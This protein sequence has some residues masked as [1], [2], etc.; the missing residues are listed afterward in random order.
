MGA[1]R[2]QT[3]VAMPLTARLM[4]GSDGQQSRIF[5]LR[6]GVRLHGDRIIAGDIAELRGQIGDQF[7]IAFLLIRRC[8]G[9]DGR[10][11]RPAQRHHFRRRVQ[12]HGAGAKRDHRPV[13]RQIAVREATHVAHH[14]GLGP[15][16]VEDRMRQIFRL[17]VHVLRHPVLGAEI[18]ICAHDA[19]G[20]PDRLDGLGARGLI[21]RDPHTGFTHAT[22]VDALINGGFH[23]RRL[24]RADI[25]GDGVKERLWVDFEASFLKTFGQTHGLAVNA[26]RDRLQPFGAVEDRIHR[27]H[28][29]Q[30]RLRGAD[31]GGRLFA[32]NMLFAGLKR[33]AVGFVAVR[34][35]R[36]ADDAARHVAFISVLGRH[37]GRVWS[38]CAHRHAKTLG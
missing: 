4:I 24:Q 13:Q 17:A 19:K 18:V 11:L 28:D 29:R 15:V 20:T 26:L 30:Q 33:Q 21:D 2:D 5:P 9:V 10:K 3:D 36:H 12:L 6:A 31:V 35:D 14:L 7:A 25:H 1:H 32:A 23:H 37:I 8:E 27:R 38:P 34:V 22:Q 16:H